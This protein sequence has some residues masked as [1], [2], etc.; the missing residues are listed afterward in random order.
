[1]RCSMKKILLFFVFLY[2]LLSPV[3]PAKA[4]EEPPEVSSHAA[5]L[6]DASTGKI[7]YEKNPDKKLEPAS[8]T[9]IMTAIVALENAELSDIVAT[10]KNPTLVEG[11]RIYLE[12]GEKLTL[13]QM[14]YALLLNSGNDAAVAIAEHV[15]GSVES[16]VDMMNN[17]AMEIGALNTT[18]VNPS[19]LSD[20]GHL[21]TARD[22]AMITRHAIQNFPEFCKIVA[23]KTLNIP[24]QGNEWDRKLQNLNRLLWDYEGADGVKT[25]YTSSAG[26]T[27]VATATRNGWQLIAVLLKSQTRPTLWNDAQSLLDYGFNN[28]Q[29][30]DVISSHKLITSA[31]VKYG[32]DVN[33]ITTEDFSTVLPKGSTITQK[34]VLDSKLSAPISKG[35]TLGKLEFYHGALKLDS[36]DLIAQNDVKRKIHTYWWF[37]PLFIAV[38]LYTPFRVFIGIRRYRRRKHQ[39]RY[40]SYIHRYK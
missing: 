11:T 18:F 33:L 2:M 15:G 3:Y 12:E 10:G 5:I 8:I 4:Q 6:V 35:Q 17:K 16:F 26:Q 38:L 34:V 24:W 7:I 20:E 22:I 1:M 27:L 30:Y 14:L 36:V 32:E 40:I 9:K 39:A 37:W 13:E 23:T 25:G 29:K 19:G 21:S 28:F 31:K